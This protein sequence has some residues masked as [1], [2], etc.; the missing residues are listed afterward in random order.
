MPILNL[1]FIKNFDEVK[2]KLNIR[3]INYVANKEMLQEIPY[4]KFLDLAIICVIEVCNDGAI[5]VN[6]NLFQMWNIE[7]KELFEIAKE[8][9]QKIQ[10]PIGQ[11]MVDIINSMFGGSDKTEGMDKFR[12]DINPMYVLTNKGKSFGASVILYDGLLEKLANEM[13]SD[14]III[15]SSVHEVII[16]PYTKDMDEL[17]I[18]SM[19]R[20]INGT[21]VEI[22]EIL[23]N[24]PY[25]YMRDVR[26]ITM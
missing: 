4:E 7:Q 13:N 12:T 5:K 11:N 8:N 20:D 17:N 23:S 3:L 15:P 18:T 25:F 1:D 21:E 6:N 10:P 9:T 24:H 2:D 14:L 26:N 22:E 16:L 19:I